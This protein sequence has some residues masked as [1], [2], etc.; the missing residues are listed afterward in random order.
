MNL[1]GGL[2][3]MRRFAGSLSLLCAI[4]SLLLFTRPTVFHAAP[5]GSGWRILREIPLA[6]DGKFD[7]IALDSAARRITPVV[8]GEASRVVTDLPPADR[9]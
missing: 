4:A 8:S 5:P 6:G 1:K 3:F 7:Y 9:P 2:G